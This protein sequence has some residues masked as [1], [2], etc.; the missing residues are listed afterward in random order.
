MNY[1]IKYRV[2]SSKGILI[3]EGQ[4]RAKNQVNEFT[5]KCK[6]EDHMRKIYSD[7]FGRLEITDFKKDFGDLDINDFF[8]GIFK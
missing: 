2:I 8:G 5:C 1:L 4:Q 6:F 3:K 7:D